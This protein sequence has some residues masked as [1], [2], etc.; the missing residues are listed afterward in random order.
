MTAKPFFKIFWAGLLTA[1]LLAANPAWADKPLLMEGKK[2][3]YQ[4]IITHPGA[5]GHDSPGGQAGNPIT[6]FSVLY[7]Y[8]REKAG[9]QDWL[10]VAAN[11]L[12]RD[13][14]WLP[15][16][17]VSEWKQSM[18]LTFSPRAGRSPLLF[19]KTFD[20]LEN[21]AGQSG[22][23]AV[24]AN[25]S[26]VFKKYVQGQTEPPSDFPVLAM[27]PGDEE[28]SVPYDHFYLMPIFSYQEPFE[29]VKF[30]EVGSIDPGYGDEES[31]D[32][33]KPGKNKGFKHAI[34]FVI[35][36]TV[37]M[38]PYIEKT[39]ELARGVFDRIAEKGQEE[40]VALGVVA[41]RNS[42]EPQPKLEYLTR[43]IS[44]LST[45]VDRANFEKT[46]AGVKEAT[47][48]SHSFN[49]DALAGV[50]EA[51]D[52]LDWDPYQG[53]MIILITDAGPL[54]ITDPYIS[55]MIGLSG[56]V[57]RAK[58]KNIKVVVLHVRTPS[59]VKT[60]N[61]TYAEGAYKE[62]SELGSA[63]R[64]YI[65]IEAPNPQVG[66]GNFAEA[67]ET[68]VETLDNVVFGQD[69]QGGGGASKTVPEGGDAKAKARATGEVLGYSFKLDYAGQT[70]QTKAPHVV[71]SW[72][73]DQDM[74]R[75]DE[76]QGGSVKAPT[77]EC[78]VLITKDQLSALNKQLE[79][80]MTE[81]E[82][83][84][85]MG[86]RDFFQ[87]IIS[88]SA[89]MLHD[90]SQFALKPD[91]N[92]SKLGILGEFLDGLPYKSR[93]LGLTEDD[94]YNMSIGEQNDFI[95]YL[96]SRL[97]YYRQ[98]DQD[99]D[100]WGRFDNPNPGDWLYRLPLVMLP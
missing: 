51:I 94:W 81:A 79:I 20:D 43:I 32:Q 48:S 10:Q 64:A 16:A 39:K 35:D 99:V 90:P 31:K 25:L 91:S 44:P 57:D 8:A 70:G 100:K 50:K 36:T 9:P 18:V 49:E 87:S 33:G 17:K 86:T 41:F 65:P 97:A 7:V 71:R 96:K 3:L 93:V 66:A 2:S 88:A 38:Q 14:V 67:A 22:L 37:S 24:L 73:A 56:V 42:L 82:R 11:T 59:G 53:R 80:I 62:L 85:K 5:L 28:G 55:T 47:A 75:L 27:E 98:A 63:G 46:L 30:L 1:G 34:A 19:F 52:K 77:V 72:I 83:N 95:F 54:P 26:R 23:A 58:K 4:R 45:G 78:A 60:K 13:L 12:G 15:A 84:Q 40:N 29:G 92:L 74:G 69:G 68:L 21:I 89:Q 6:P 61:V 76:A